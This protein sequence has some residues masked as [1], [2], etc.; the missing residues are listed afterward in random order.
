[1]L[2]PN[3]TL[4]FVRGS[5]STSF[6]VRAGNGLFLV[7]VSIGLVFLWMVEINLVL[8]VARNHMVLV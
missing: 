6:C 1:M 5:K 3:L 2:G 7:W 4:F 8:Y